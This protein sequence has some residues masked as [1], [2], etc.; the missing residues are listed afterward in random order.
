MLHTITNWIHSAGSKIAQRN[1]RARR[2]RRRCVARRFSTVPAMVEP[3]EDRVML[4]A[5]IT[6]LGLAA[7]NFRL[8]GN[9]LAFSVSESEQAD[10]D[11]NGDGD[12]TD[13]VMHVFDASTGT[14]TNVGRNLYSNRFELDGN[15]LAFSVSEFGEGGTDLNG[16]GD[17][18]DL[19][20]HVFDA[21]AGTTANLGLAVNNAKPPQLDGNLLAFRVREDLQGGT[22]LNGDGDATDSVL[23]VYDAAAGMTTNLGRVAVGAQLDGNLLAFSV[24]EF[25]EGG[26][27]LNGDGDAN[28]L[29]LHVFDAGAGTTT[30]LGLDGGFVIQLDGN[31]LAFVVNEARQGGAD[32]NGDGDARDLVQHVYDASTGTTTNLGLVP[33]ESQLDG[34]L[35][36]FGVLESSQGGTDL[37]GDGDAND[38]VLHVFDAGAGTTTNLGLDGINFRLHGG[39][40]AFPV[41]ESRQGGADLNGDGDAF[42]SVLHIYDA[43]AGTTSNLGLSSVEIQLDGNLLAFSVSEAGQGGTDLNGD[44]NA[45]DNV[46]H[47]FDA[48]TGTTTNLGLDTDRRFLLDGNLLTFGVR[49]SHQ[50]GTDLNGDGDATD[51][52][53]HVY[54]ADTGTTTNLGLAAFPHDFLL[55]GNLLAVFVWEDAQGGTDLNGDGDVFDDVMHVVQLPTDSDGDGISDKVDTLP[56]VFSANFS[57]GTTIGTIT[58][59]GDQQLSIVDAQDPVDGV[60]ARAGINGG[61]TPA[62][63][64]VSGGAA[65]YTLNAGDE[66]VITEGSVITDVIAGV[67][68]ITF[69]GDDGSIFT[70][71]LDGGTTQDGEVQSLT[72]EPDTLVF[73]TPSTNTADVVVLIDGQE[74]TVTPGLSLHVVGIDIKPDSDPN[75]INLGSG[76]T[77]AVAILSTAAFDATTVDPN[78]VTLAN[79]EVRL[80][81]NSTPMSSEQDVNSDGLL[82]LVVHVET[83]ALE[84]TDGDVE[85]MLRGK[86]L[87]GDPI[88]GTDSVRIVAALHVAGGA[89]APGSATEQLLDAALAPFAAQAVALWAATGLAPEAR[90]LL[91]AIEARVADLPGSLLGLATGSGVIWID[92]NAAGHGWFVDPTPADSREFAVR[93]A[94][95]HRQASPGSDAFGRIDLLTVLAHEF[96]H[97]LGRVDL[98][99]QA[100]PHNVMAAT[101]APGARRTPAG[102]SPHGAA[103]SEQP[104]HSSAAVGNTGGA[105]GFNSRGLLGVDPLPGPLQDNGGP[106]R[107]HALLAESAAID[108]ADGVFAPATD[109]RGISRPQDGDGDGAALAGI[110]ALERTAADR[111]F[112]DLDGGLLDELLSSGLSA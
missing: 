92:H 106:T 26:T 29:V 80:K 72:F 31:L 22:D 39:L 89:A 60:L 7:S 6:N 33:Y 68:E 79:A 96:G 23:H 102:D 111:L 44:G 4:A 43:S 16:D 13:V 86:T 100:H 50:G 49:E 63:V 42:D 105:S 107:T 14:T 108:T 5:D 65:I 84:L 70:T 21:G 98:D 71:T 69:T 1:G 53:L 83:E 104:A 3:L 38:V 11:F 54:D 78:T 46:L 25:G 35:L 95:T 82:D 19:V 85:A 15:L 62:T 32:L 27:D 88:F 103:A 112:A 9:L 34:N 109:R 57:D 67:V 48:S 40:L 74:L 52:V 73:S 41:D 51:P 59:R 28:D 20:L 55:D 58:D 97:L 110:A 81:G 76:G 47:V 36:A 24:S 101:F 90:D 8:D 66:V 77:V 94:P 64:S 2:R 75:S 17:A 87:A 93:L 37:N 12:A 45:F 61:P 91:H 99:P 56:A 30:N 10:T 18:Q